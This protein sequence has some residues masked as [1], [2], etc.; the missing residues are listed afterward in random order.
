VI[1]SQFLEGL[2]AADVRVVLDAGTKRRIAP[3]AI[4]YEQGT[5]ANEFFLLTTGH[6]RYFSLGPD[7]R[8]MLLHWLV[9]GDILG[10]VS[11]LRS[12]AAYRVSAETV[13]ESSLIVWTRS[14]MLS[15]ADRYPR[16]VQNALVVGAGYL[17][18]YIAAY[19]ALVSETAR[20]RLAN[21]LARLGPAIGREVPGGVELTVTNEELASAANITP[22]TASRILSEWQDSSVV[23]KR[24]GRIILHAP[25]RLF[26][27][28]A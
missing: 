3:H 26:S 6:A 2:E 27:K 7:G 13:Q 20:E 10:V 14:T 25:G 21:V 28:T 23:T 5:Q 16:L 4:I 9:P 19:S 18:L 12:P 24:R 15:L 8:R 22:F 17:D 1:V 11:M